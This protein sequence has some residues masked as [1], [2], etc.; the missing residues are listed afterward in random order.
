MLH[1]IEHRDLTFAHYGSSFHPGG[2]NVGDIERV[3]ELA[4]FGVARVGDQIGFG[5]AW[6]FDIPGVGFDGNM[7]LE[8]RA[9]FGAPVE[10][11]FQL[12]LLGLEAAVDG[13]GTD[14]EELLLGWL[15]DRQALDGPRQP[16]GKRALIRAENG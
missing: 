1:G 4:L 6:G 8:Q 14:R 16:Q 3:D 9:G 12:A 10:T 15:R 7:V 11:L 13:S 5:K 2:V